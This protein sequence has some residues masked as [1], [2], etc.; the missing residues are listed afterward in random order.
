MQL[1]TMKA[2]LPNILLVLVFLQGCAPYRSIKGPMD[3]VE[4]NL[5]CR[6]PPDTLIVFLPGAYDNPQDLITQGFV[7]AVRERK[8]YANVQLVDAHTGYYTSQ[9]ILQRLEAEVIE[10]AK[11]KGYKRIWF[12]G[13]SLGG[14]GTMLYAMKHPTALDGFFIMAPYMG[15]RDIPSEILRQGGLKSWSSP[16]ESNTDIDLWRWLQGYGGGQKSGRPQAWLGYGATDRFAQAN[17]LM[18]TVLPIDHSFVIP[19]GHDWSTWRQLWAKFLDAAP[20]PRI[21]TAASACAGT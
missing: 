17:G 3:S 8:I 13:I 10:P 20:L 11:V 15:W 6:V 16:A 14:Y 18:A 2:V 1:R 4:D 21:D 12:A 9:Q 19:G 5:Q 7:S